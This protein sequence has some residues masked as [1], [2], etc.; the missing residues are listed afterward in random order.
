MREYLE[1]GTKAPDFEAT[2][3]NG[4]KIKLSDFK[5]K[6]VAL[7]FYPKDDTPG[8]TKQACNLRDNKQ[9]LLDKNIQIIG[10]SKDSVESHQKFIAKY[11]LP[12]P[13]LV[14]ENLEIT[15]QYKAYGEKN[16][17]GKISMGVYRITYLIDEDGTII[18]LVKRVKTTEHNEQ[19]LN[20][21]EKH[22][23]KK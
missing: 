18:G 4:D 11:D 9:E 6:K 12:F 8:C 14:D 2:D 1:L 21:L 23:S 5:G 16:M 3:Q 22:Q 19:L 15:K 10:V 20:L 7:Y 17:Y 13:L